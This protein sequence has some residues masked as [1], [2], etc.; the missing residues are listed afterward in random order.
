MN[1]VVAIAYGLD[2]KVGSYGEKHVF[3]FDLGGGTFDVSLLALIYTYQLLS[4]LSHS[5][6]LSRL[7]TVT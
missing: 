4:L 2:E 6:S 7:F 1:I 3:I 5:S